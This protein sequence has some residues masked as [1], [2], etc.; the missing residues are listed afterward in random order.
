MQFIDALNARSLSPRTIIAYKHDIQKFA[1]M[2]GRDFHFMTATDIGR[3]IEDLTHSGA[4]LSTVKRS[5][6]AIREFFSFCIDHGSLTQNPAA[7][8]KITSV[9]A[10]VLAPETVSSLFQYLL[11]HQQTSNRAVSLRYRRD[12]L[13]LYLMIFC[14][15]RQYQFPLLKLSSISH[16]GE[17]LTLR[18]TPGLLLELSGPIIPKLRQYLSLRDSNSDTIFLEPLD[19]TPMSVSAVHSLLQEF[20]YRLGLRCTSTGL[21]HTFL[22]FLHNPQDRT[23]LFSDIYPAESQYTPRPA[24]SPGLFLHA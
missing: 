23:I 8:L 9:P 5:L 7:P 10:D 14:G 22:H 18:I 16:N 15:V 20:N 2:H 21:Y 17:I 13:I 6:S 12:E 3:Y 24:N 11:E 4:K 19:G 1:S